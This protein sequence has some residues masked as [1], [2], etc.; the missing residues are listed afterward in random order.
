MFPFSTFD[1]R[2]SLSP[3]LSVAWPPVEQTESMQTRGACS[4]DEWCLSTFSGLSDPLRPLRLSLS[5]SSATSN[6]L[7]WS[8]KRCGRDAKGRSSSPPSLIPELSSTEGRRFRSSEV[9]NQAFITQYFTYYLTFFCSGLIIPNF[10]DLPSPS[11]QPSGTMNSKS[12]IYY[13]KRDEEA[14]S[15]HHRLMHRHA[16]HPLSDHKL[17]VFPRQGRGQ[18]NC[19]L[20]V[21]FF[22]A[23]P[24]TQVLFSR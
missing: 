16:L 12:T 13:G 5:L 14:P 6:F 11:M 9:E 22:A 2:L 10:L 24:V 1:E 15:V 3:S 18:W 4:C 20:L 17:P 8:S 21:S 7:A 19:Q 23:Y